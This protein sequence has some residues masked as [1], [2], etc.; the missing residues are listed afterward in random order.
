MVWTAYAL[1]ACGAAVAVI[2]ELSYARIWQPFF[3]PEFDMNNYWR[4]AAVGQTT[5]MTL[6]PVVLIGCGLG[7]LS[8]YH[9]AATRPYLMMLWMLIAFALPTP[10]I[11]WL[12]WIAIYAIDA[13]TLGTH[14]HTPIPNMVVWQNC[15]VIVSLVPAFA[16]ASY[17]LGCIAGCRRIDKRPQEASVPAEL[18]TP[19]KPAK[20]GIVSHASV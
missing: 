19:V 1:I 8:A 4:I 20:G 7:M 13:A 12:V 16:G 15:F 6:V 2:H 11:H 18:P 17:L 5:A 3:S 9:R 14:S 10:L